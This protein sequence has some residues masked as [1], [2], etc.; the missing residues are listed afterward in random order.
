M[1]NPKK[2]SDGGA[3]RTRSIGRWGAAWGGAALLL[4]LGPHLDAAEGGAAVKVEGAG[5][6]FQLAENWQTLDPNYFNLLKTLLESRGGKDM[7]YGELL[8]MFQRGPREQFVPLQTPFM[9]VARSENIVSPQAILVAY[10]K[11]G[12]ILKDGAKRSRDLVSGASVG[13]ELE[14]DGKLG[15]L[16]STGAFRLPTGQD[17]PF[18][19]FTL[20][21]R[22]GVVQFVI[23]D[24]IVPSEELSVEVGLMMSKVEVENSL[25]VDQAFVTELTS[26][27][28]AEKNKDAEAASK[29]PKIGR[30]HV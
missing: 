13:N 8:M 6:T 3:R 15:M 29:G 28:E 18:R 10:F 16:R 25:R 2:S 26:L 23:F 4:A 17:C 27:I 30:A 22:S 20:P 11:A 9:I 1:R 21:T 7:R 5:V 12:G 24:G 19:G 14:W